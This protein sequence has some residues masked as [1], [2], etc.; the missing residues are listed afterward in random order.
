MIP[1]GRKG[2]KGSMSYFSVDIVPCIAF[3]LTSCFTIIRLHATR[4]AM[5]LN[6]NEISLTH[7]SKNNSNVI[8]KYYSTIG[9]QK[10]A[11]TIVYI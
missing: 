1:N 10:R 2:K 8:S 11:V 6:L 3:A 7:T 5:A 4:L 9:S